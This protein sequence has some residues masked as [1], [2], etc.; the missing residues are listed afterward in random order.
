MDKYIAKKYFLLVFATMFTI[1]GF[2]ACQGHRSEGNGPLGTH[3]HRTP[4]ESTAP[5]CTND[6]KNVYK[7]WCGYFIEEPVPALGHHYVE[8]SC[9]RCN[10][11]IMEELE[12]TLSADG[13]YYILTR[14]GNYSAS[15][16]I[17]PNTYK[18]LP[19]TEIG[20]DAFRN[21]PTTLISVQLG[22]A[23]TTIADNAFATS[24]IQNITLGNG[25][26]SIGN[27]AF[28]SCAITSIDLPQSLT[29]IGYWAF[30][31]SDLISITIPDQVTKIE[32]DTFA[33][34]DDLQTVI[35]GDGVTEIGENAFHQCTALK[36][37]IIGKK[38]NF[39]ATHAFY[40]CT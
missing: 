38:V 13:T 20:K 25:L 26:I 7:C 6:G 1:V 15:T 23:I 28:S 14:L 3:T 17:V 22:D 27:H 30:S 36:N 4:V 12:F 19:V 32:H 40:K 8:M 29:T 31:D 11:S 2:S 10:Q 35:I 39:V 24:R 21:A 37:V 9:E 5:T 33:L 16:L 18:D 34:C